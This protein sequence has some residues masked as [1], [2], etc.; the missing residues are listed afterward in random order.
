MSGPEVN[1]AEFCPK[2]KDGNGH[3]NHW[4]DGDKPCCWC[5]DDTEEK[6]KT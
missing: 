3:C 4:W 5:G 2:S 1:D 6:E